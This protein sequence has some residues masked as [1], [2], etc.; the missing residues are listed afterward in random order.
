MDTNSQTTVPSQKVNNTQNS[1]PSHNMTN[2]DTNILFES[3]AYLYQEV[4]K[5]T[6]R[7]DEL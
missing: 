5:L 7:V 4:V 3:L 2:L 6:L 1:N